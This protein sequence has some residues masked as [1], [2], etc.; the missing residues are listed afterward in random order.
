MDSQRYDISY[1]NKMS[2]VGPNSV[3]LFTN[4]SM[5]V[6]Y[7]FSDTFLCQSNCTCGI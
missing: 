3:Y 4:Q 7:N 2:R 1:P 6:L 5:G